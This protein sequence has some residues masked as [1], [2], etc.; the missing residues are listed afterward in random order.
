VK[1]NWWKLIV[2]A[3]LVA[4]VAV[5]VAV[6]NNA[7]DAGTLVAKDSGLPAPVDDRTAEE[8]VG[9][10]T[11]E[12]PPKPA[13]PTEAAKPDSSAA[14]DEPKD[15]TQAAAAVKT[16]AP[17]TGG[18]TPKASPAEKPKAVRD[19]TDWHMIRGEIIT[20]RDPQ[21]SLP[22]IDQL[23]GFRGMHS[24][25]RRVLVPAATGGSV[26]SVW[27]YVGSRSLIQNARPTNKTQWP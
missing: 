2:V 13:T 3:A 11:E 15:G 6:K 10:P 9:T 21:M 7:P 25:Y 12:A 4:A 19:E 24:T 20:L 8:A 27:C 23:E 1:Q 17:R 18:E 5:V 14:L 26:L 22:P 16:P